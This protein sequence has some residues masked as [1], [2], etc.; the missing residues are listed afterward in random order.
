MYVIIWK[1][2][3]KA[4]R[5][6]EFEKIYKSNGVWAELFRKG[7]GFMS[8]ELLHDEMHSQKYITIDRWD[9]A[10]CYEAFHSQFKKEYETLDAQCQGLTEQ[11]SLLGKWETVNYETR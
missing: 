5:S 7:S 8:T 10:E 4:D 3:V 9:S 6:N 2:Q 1:Y 11:E